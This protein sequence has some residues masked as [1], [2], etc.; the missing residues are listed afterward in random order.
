MLESKDLHVFRNVGEHFLLTCVR[1]LRVTVFNVCNSC[2]EITSGTVIFEGLCLGS[3]I[4]HVG[5]RDGVAHRGLV[6]S[7]T[8]LIHRFGYIVR[9]YVTGNEV[10]CTETIFR[11]D[12]LDVAYIAQTGDNIAL[13]FVLNIQIYRSSGLKIAYRNDQFL[14]RTHCYC[15]HHG[16]CKKKYFFHCF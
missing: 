16:S 2:Q 8:I 3:T 12:H 1:I 9:K 11:L 13:H 15:H 7:L 6:P 4:F 14:T 10:V 5:S